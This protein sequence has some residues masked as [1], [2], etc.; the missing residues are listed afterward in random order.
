MTSH[1][2]IPKI[3]HYCWYGKG[4]L[5]EEIRICIDSWK[6]FCPDYEIKCWNEDNTPMDIPWIRDA[7]HHQ[8][9]AFVADYVRFYALYHEG[10]IYMDTDML[11]KKNLDSL[12]ENHLFMGLQDALSINAA[13]MGSEPKNKYLADILQHYDSRIFDMMRPPIITHVLTDLFA[14]SGWKLEGDILHSFA[15]GEVVL[16]PSKVFY[17]IHYTQSFEW[18]EIDNFCTDE[19]VGVHL[20]NKSWTSEFELLSKRK[21]KEGFSMAWARIKRTPFLPI[22]YYMKLAKC[23]LQYLRR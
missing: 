5:S 1:I 3:I 2:P 8:K 4:V 23:I 22:R 16:Y 10:G 12:L 19:T 9:Y 11:L 15:D 7:Y 17:P 20:W 6:R 18:H 14:Q 13:I 21:Y